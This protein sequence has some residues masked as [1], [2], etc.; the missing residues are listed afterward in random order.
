M[1]LRTSGKAEHYRYYTCCT[2]A[3]KGTTGCGGRTV[4]MHNLDS[5]VVDY[6][7]QRLLDP[8][9]LN[10]IPAPCW[11]GV[12][13]KAT[14]I[15]IGSPSS[16]AKPPTPIASLRASMRPLRMGWPTRRMRT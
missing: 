2:K 7:E 4:P 11:K 1:T 9:R 15:W 14:G 5:L 12:N 10:E 6:L 3:R 8:E 13:R 16:S